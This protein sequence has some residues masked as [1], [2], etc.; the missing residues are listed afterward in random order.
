MCGTGDCKHFSYL[1]KNY[2]IFNQL[3]V[4]RYQNSES[5]NSRANGRRRKQAFYKRIM[6]GIYNE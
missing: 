1:T 4:K 2:H 6:K 3:P 5:C